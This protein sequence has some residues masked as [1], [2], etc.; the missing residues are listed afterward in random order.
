MISVSNIVFERLT[1]YNKVGLFYFNIFYSAWNIKR[2]CFIQY[3]FY[4]YL[5]DLQLLQIKYL[6]SPVAQFT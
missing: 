5:F 4:L 1:E 6:G 3:Y 2:A